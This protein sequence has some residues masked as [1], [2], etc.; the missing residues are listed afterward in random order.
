M[1]ILY[2]F[3]FYKSISELPKNILNY[4]DNY[5]WEPDRRQALAPDRCP[6]VVPN[7]LLDT[8]KNQARDNTWQSYDIC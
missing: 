6:A 1:K 5:N 4:C 8:G 7:A 3:H 2:D